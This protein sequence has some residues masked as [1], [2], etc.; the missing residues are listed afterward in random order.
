MED[1][2]ELNCKL[3][4]TYANKRNHPEFGNKT[5]CKHFNDIIVSC[6]A[7]ICKNVSSVYDCTFKVCVEYLDTI[8]KWFGPN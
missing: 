5:I 2:E 6:E 1:I 7:G 4:D 8:C 3:N